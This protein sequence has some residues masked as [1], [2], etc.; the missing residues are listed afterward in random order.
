MVKERLKIIYN[1]GLIF[2]NKF[3]ILK[4]QICLLKRLKF[5]HN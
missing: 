3:M 2:L 1:Y 4:Q 5:V